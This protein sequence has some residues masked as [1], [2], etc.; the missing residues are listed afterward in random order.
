MLKEGN[1]LRIIECKA[2]K[3]LSVSRLKNYIKTDKNTNEI[4]G[5]NVNYA[6][7]QGLDESYFTNP[8]IN[9]EFILYINSPESSAIASKLDLPASLPYNIK[10]D[11]EPYSGFV[12]IIVVAVNK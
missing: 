11:G 8:N 9:K 10:I 5:F 2:V 3:D 7:L 6:L 4:T 12:D 1:T